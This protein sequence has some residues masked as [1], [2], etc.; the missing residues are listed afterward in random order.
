MSILLSFAEWLHHLFSCLIKK[1]FYWNR[2]IYP[3]D[4]L[5]ESAEGVPVSR[6]FFQVI[7]SLLMLFSYSVLC[8]FCFVYDFLNCNY[9]VQFHIQV[10]FQSTFSYWLLFRIQLLSVFS[11]TSTSIRAFKGQ[12][13]ALISLGEERISSQR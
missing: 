7:L 9:F 4:S 1:V 3:G 6:S 2:I 10:E 5:W 8:Q 11:L 12:G 13:R